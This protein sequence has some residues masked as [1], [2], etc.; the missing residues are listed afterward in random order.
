MTYSAGVPQLALCAY[1]PDAEH[2]KSASKVD[3]KAW[4]EHVLETVGGGEIVK[5]GPAKSPMG[6]T[7]VMARIAAVPEKGKFPL[8]DKDASMAAAFAF[9]RS[10]DAFPDDKDDSDDEMVFGDD[11]NLDDY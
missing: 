6:G 1:V 11:C 7:V 3:C 4:M 5:A 9:L 10:K 8:K 2:N